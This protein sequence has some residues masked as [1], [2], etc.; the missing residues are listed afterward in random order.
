MTPSYVFTSVT[1]SIKLCLFFNKAAIFSLDISKEWND[2][3]HELPYI[4]SMVALMCLVTSFASLVMSAYDNSATLFFKK[5]YTTSVPYGF[6][7]HVQPI[8]LLSFNAA[9]AAI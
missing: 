6:L 5:S 3:K 2:V 9:G 4:S 7:Q 8:N 1:N